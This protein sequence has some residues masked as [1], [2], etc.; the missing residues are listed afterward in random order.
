DELELRATKLKDRNAM[1]EDMTIKL[2]NYAKALAK[3]DKEKEEFSTMISDELKR[4]VIPIIGYC[5]LI[6]DGSLGE[7]GKKP[8]EKVEIMLERAWSLQNLVQNILD[9][10]RLD[11]G[12]LKMNV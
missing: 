3:A 11:S 6:L 7:I 1:L 4:F 2:D 9:V 5:E 12:I 8:K 10:R